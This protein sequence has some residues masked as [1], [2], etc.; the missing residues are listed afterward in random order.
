MP[1]ILTL[2]SLF[3]SAV[4]PRHGIFVEERLKHLVAGTGIRSHVLAPVPWFPFTHRRFGEYA[5]YARTASREERH[6]IV[7]DYPRYPAIPKVGMSIAP[8]LMAMALL[9]RVRRLLRTEPD[10]ALIDGH[11]LYPDGVAACLLGRWVGL[12]VVITARGS[13]VNL[14]SRF[15]VPRAWLQWAIGSAAAVITV[16][17]ALRDKLLAMG[18]EPGKVTTLRNGVDLARFHPGDRDAARTRLGVAGLT[19]LSVGN[20]LELK[21]HHIL[22]DALADLK[23]ATAVIAGDGPLRS[24]LERRAARLGVGDRV[25]FLGNV[26]QEELVAWYN[27]ADYLVLTSSREGMPNVVLESLACGTPVI[28]TAV[29]GVPELIDSDD[30]GYQLPERSPAALVQAVRT[31]EASPLDRR[32]VARHGATFGWDPTIQGLDGLIGEI[33]AGR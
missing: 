24:E 29:G 15:T 1:H 22:V 17:D 2:S 13:D 14:Y 3:P 12:Q 31:L 23:D 30:V 11:F 5:N 10:I 4:R 9:P 25:R 19:L 21:G 26:A 18:A 32:R 20:L 28:A 33:A 7:V 16:S 27:A 8:V 6:G